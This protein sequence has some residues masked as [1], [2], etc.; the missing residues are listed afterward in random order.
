M[1][2]TVCCNLVVALGG[3]L[4][5]L[6]ALFGCLYAIAA[7]GWLR[8][9]R[10][11]SISP[12]HPRPNAA[13]QTSIPWVE[14]RAL[15]GSAVVIG[16]LAVAGIHWHHDPVI[17]WGSVLI[18]LAIAA[19]V[20]TRQS[21]REIEKPERSRSTETALWVLAIA[22]VVVT[23]VSHRPDR[24]DAFYVNLAVAT[25][26]SPSRPLLAG[27]TLHGIPDLPLYLSVYRVHAYELLNGAVSYLTGIP[28]I[29]CM[30][31][32]AAAI[33]ALF[34]PLAHARLFRVLTPR[35]WLVSV[36]VMI[37][38]LV[39]VGGIYFW[40]GNF[41]FIR[42][43]QGKGI[44]LFIF[45]PLVY[46]Y[47]LE[48]AHTTSLRCWLLL[49]AAQIAAM[50]S[51]ATAIWLAPFGA[52]VAL[53]SG[54]TL[55]RA[56]LRTLVLGVLASSYLLCIGFLLRGDIK[57]VIETDHIVR[58]LGEPLHHALN[59]VVGEAS[60][61][62]FA[63]VSIAL[64][65]TVCAPGPA[66]RFAIAIPLVAAATLLNP[67]AVDL[68]VGELIGP[69]FWRSL[70]ALP[71]PILMTLVLVSPLW[72]SNAVGNSSRAR[73]LGRSLFLALVAVF[74]LAVPG[75]GGLTEANRV[76]LRW[77]GLKVPTYQY[78]LAEEL[79][80]GVGPGAYV[81]A[82]HSISEWVPTF[83]DHAFPLVVRHY[84]TDQEDALGQE[85]LSARSWLREFA[86]NPTGD[87][88]TTERFRAG[89]ERFEVSGVCLHVNGRSRA[90]IETLLALGFKV[91]WRT[92]FHEIWVRDLFE[93]TDPAAAA[94]AHSFPATN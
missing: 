49:C 88:A 37:L 54:V 66:R 36:T 58:E 41:A 86:T 7:L 68:V 56:G 10:S 11:V 91:H 19:F 2:W 5:S 17:A 46:V 6:L 76:Y 71:V 22:C 8:W 16:V 51:S 87:A 38:V 33:A 75:T 48:F 30:H 40:Y 93:R 63:L 79:N 77:P 27:D 3:S 42:I 89:L 78:E 94:N 29:Y 72:V 82:P 61:R 13:V 52:G 35:H 92:D 70:W 32:L 53:L 15:Y 21:T 55:S 47:A 69:Y 44:L 12:P 80:R 64:A 83:H 31:L 81:V 34:V 74:A 57:S 24:D 4:I 26:D 18:T 1:L 43:W 60:L 59:R 73:W 39:S 85:E 9:R 50:G 45:M 28:A 62:S 90:V 25:A 65:W 84:L 67:F 23:L 20:C 14:P